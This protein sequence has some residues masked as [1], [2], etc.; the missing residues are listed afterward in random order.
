[1]KKEQLYNYED[2]LEMFFK[3]LANPASKNK[4]F[5]MN[6]VGPDMIL[7]GTIFDMEG[8]NYNISSFSYEQLGLINQYN[9]DGKHYQFL[10]YPDIPASVMRV[11]AIYA[12]LHPEPSN[13]LELWKLGRSGIKN[14]Y[15]MDVCCCILEEGFNLADYIIIENEDIRLLE[16]RQEQAKMLELN[17]NM[18]IFSTFSQADINKR[19]PIN[20]YIQT[21]K[22]SSFNL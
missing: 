10:C 6:Q 5:T 8:C 17:P 1:M 7:G 16:V 12:D 13:R 11:L 15:I 3:E 20:D 14:P 18:L 9:S 21:I 19:K 4:P 2:D 22:N